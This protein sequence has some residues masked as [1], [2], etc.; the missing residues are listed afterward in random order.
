MFEWFRNS[1]SPNNS[2]TNSLTES[3]HVNWVRFKNGRKRK[4]NKYKI[5]NAQNPTFSGRRSFLPKVHL[6]P[7]LV[8]PC[9]LVLLYRQFLLALLVPPRREC[10]ALP[11]HWDKGALQLSVPGAKLQ[12][13]GTGQSS[14]QEEF[15][16]NRHRPQSAHTVEELLKIRKW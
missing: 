9:L 7:C 15:H 11:V 12:Q 3:I 16:Q 1:L 10:Q 8:L 14:K 2:L 4:Q 6:F 5:R 13:P